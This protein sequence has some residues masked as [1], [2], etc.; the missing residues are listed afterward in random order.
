MRLT[1]GMPARPLLLFK[2]PDKKNGSDRDSSIMVD[3]NVT[4]TLKTLRGHLSNS[5][6]AKDED[7][8]Q[9]H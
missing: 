4:G 7:D 3:V 9:M 6:N 2:Q 5:D 8:Y 1:V